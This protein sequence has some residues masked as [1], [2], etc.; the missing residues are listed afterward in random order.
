MSEINIIISVDDE[1]LE[2][3]LEVV[4]ALEAVGMK[5]ENIMPE[6]GV[7]SGSIDAAKS[8]ALSNIEGVE[9][10]EISRNMKAI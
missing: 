3:I 9:Y 5:V 1:H 7:I 2:T 4:S 6:V 10:V 8:E